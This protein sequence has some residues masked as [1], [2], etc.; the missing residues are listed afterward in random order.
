MVTLFLI[1][2]PDVDP[3][4][5][6]FELVARIFESFERQ[7]KGLPPLL[8]EEVGVKMD[9][10]DSLSGTIEPLH[11]YRMNWEQ[12]KESI[13]QAPKARLIVKGNNYDAVVCLE[14]S[15]C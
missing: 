5:F 9:D 13:E 6:D 3:H 14:L 10:Y 7:E 15:R 12:L 11:K 4:D 8:V 2:P 1:S